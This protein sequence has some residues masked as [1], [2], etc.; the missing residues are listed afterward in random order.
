MADAKGF[1]I[2][3]NGRLELCWQIDGEFVSDPALRSWIF[4][5]NT[6]SHRQYVGPVVRACHVDQW[7]TRATP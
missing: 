5:N 7:A 4:H 2:D 3:Q 6:D 1:W